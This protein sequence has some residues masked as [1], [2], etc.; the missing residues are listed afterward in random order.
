M[1]IGLLVA[2]LV[3]LL[4]SPEPIYKVR[5]WIKYRVREIKRIL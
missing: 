2:I 5:S 1:I 3:T 4:L